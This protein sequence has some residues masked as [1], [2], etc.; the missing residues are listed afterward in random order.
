MSEMRNIAEDLK[1]VRD[2]VVRRERT[3]R[4]PAALAYLW[5][6][7]VL[8]GYGLLDFHRTG[9]AIFFAV[10]GFVGGILSWQ[11]GKR[12]VQQS[13][14]CDR[15][16]GRRAMIHF[17]GGI[18][19]AWIFCIALAATI[20]PLRG[21]KGS[22]VFV[23]M[24]GIIYFLWGVHEDPYYLFLGPVLMVGGVLV[25]LLPHYGWTTLGAVIAFG[26]IA[27]TFFPPRADSG[28]VPA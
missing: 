7:Y 27:P 8:I 1:F 21:S 5:A 15:A 17:A 20:E 23:V 12:Y 18:L 9:A 26:L 3:G 14:E 16:G 24:I 4:G 28:P 13:G 10:G 25:G 6:G 2:A 19:L 22:Q 11:I